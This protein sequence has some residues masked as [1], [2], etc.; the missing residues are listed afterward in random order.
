LSRVPSDA[1][2][3]INA[4]SGTIAFEPTGAIIREASQFHGGSDHPQE[5]IATAAPITE[6]GNPGPGLAGPAPPQAPIAL[7]E[8]AIPDRHEFGRIVQGR[9]VDV[10]AGVSVE[11]GSCWGGPRAG[12]RAVG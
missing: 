12:E 10:E 5:Q 2:G 1:I 9:L 11:A 6:I 4:V 3:R 8:V 7:I